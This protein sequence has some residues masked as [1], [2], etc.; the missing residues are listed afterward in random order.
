MDKLLKK[1]LMEQYKNRTVIGGVYCIKCN[2]NG[3][4]WIKAT[5]EISGEKNKFNFS[6]STNSCPEPSM[7]TAWNQYG[8]NSFSFIVLEE[9][10]KGETQTDE[11]FAA[12]V[13]ALLEIW[14]EAE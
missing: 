10:K 11:E 5:K 8:G 3:H 6:V 12:D 14:L 4:T 2:D 1:K 7:R 13:A 9:L